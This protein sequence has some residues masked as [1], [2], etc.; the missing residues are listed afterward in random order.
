MDMIVRTFWEVDILY[1]KIEIIGNFI[2]FHNQM[3]KKNIAVSVKETW[4]QFGNTFG[5][6]TI[7]ALLLMWPLGSYR[8]LS[9]L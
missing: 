5:I 4:E 6:Y 1:N 3:H 8:S 2:A 9:V 7:K